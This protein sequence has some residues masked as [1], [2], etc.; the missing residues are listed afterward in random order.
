M[1]KL[2]RSDIEPLRMMA[3]YFAERGEY[4]LAAEVYN[5]LNDTRSLV[6]MYVGAHAWEDVS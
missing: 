4:T 1:R 5:L 3:K 6:L 2:D